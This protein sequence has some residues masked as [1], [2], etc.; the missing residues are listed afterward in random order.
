MDATLLPAASV[1]AANAA[2]VGG[3]PSVAGTP[4]DMPAD[5]AALLA[6]LLGTSEPA[7]AEMPEDPLPPAVEAMADGTTEDAAQGVMD[8]AAPPPDLPLGTPAAPPSL[9]VPDLFARM[10]SPPQPGPVTPEATPTDPATG[11]GALHPVSAAPSASPAP[12]ASSTPAAEVP[13]ATMPAASEPPGHPSQIPP[14]VATEAPD[15][16]GSHIVTASSQVAAPPDAAPDTPV[17]TPIGVPQAN[18]AVMTAAAAAP[19]PARPVRVAAEAVP[20]VSAPSDPAPQGDTPR[21][22]PVAT[23]PPPIAL[24]PA[25]AEG[26]PMAIALEP[27]PSAAPPDPRP[28]AP[29]DAMAAAPET[30]PASGPT[31]ASA[32]T[33]TAPEP[34]AAPPRPSAPIPWPARQVVPFAVSLALG[35]DDSISLTLDPVELGRVEVAITRG[36]EA[37]VSL[38][39]ERPETLALLQR[40]RAELERALAGTGLGSESRSP[41]LSFGL[42]FGGSGD[43]RRDRRPAARDGQAARPAMATPAPLAHQAA[44]TARGLIDLAF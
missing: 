6:G 7:Q 21:A 5:F 32:A 23:P 16:P 40:D 18:A 25:P 4:G 34:T 43:D 8:S 22:L 44:P 39:A 26:A 38:R 2:C 3:P 41:N 10:V 1:P 15:A 9:T 28:S 13:D 33:V 31:G 37:H 27:A 20:H 29:T 42:G 11:Q 19:P 17:T 24:S 14:S 12:T 35:S 36:A 30:P